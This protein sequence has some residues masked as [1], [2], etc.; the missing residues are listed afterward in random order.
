MQ[1]YLIQLNE[2]LQEIN[3]VEKLDRFITKDVSDNTKAIVLFEQNDYEATFALFKELA[4]KQ[5]TVQSLN[6]LAWMYLREEED[7]DEAENLW[8]LQ[9]K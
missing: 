6:N 1:L 7:M 8:K 9:N 2:K 4:T 3:Y 5:P